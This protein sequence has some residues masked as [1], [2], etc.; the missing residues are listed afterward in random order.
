MKKVLPNISLRSGRV[1]GRLTRFL[2]SGLSSFSGPWFSFPGCRNLEESHCW[3][4]SWDGANRVPTCQWINPFFQ[5]PNSKSD[6]Q[7]LLLALTLPRHWNLHFTFHMSHFSGTTPGLKHDKARALHKSWGFVAFQDLGVWSPHQNHLMPF[8][9]DF[10][11]QH[12]DSLYT[13]IY[14]YIYM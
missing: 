4:P 8:D 3:N 10:K 5:G 12:V 13:Y 9:L 11:T 7:G 6:H 1:A 14:L 2:A